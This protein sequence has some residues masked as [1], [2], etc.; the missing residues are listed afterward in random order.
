MHSLT[1]ELACD[2]LKAYIAEDGNYR[3]MV[4]WKHNKCP[5]LNSSIRVDSGSSSVDKRN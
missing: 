5:C 1:A 2:W 3:R 4:R